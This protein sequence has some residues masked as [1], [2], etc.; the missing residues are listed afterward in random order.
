MSGSFLPKTRG[1]T[2]LA[3]LGVSMAF[4]CP[5]AADPVWG[6]ASTLAAKPAPLPGGLHVS[7]LRYDE[8]REHLGM[9]ISLP[10]LP[11][12]S[13]HRDIFTTKNRH[14][15]WRNGG[16]SDTV[17][18]K[19]PYGMVLSAGRSE[20][21]SGGPMGRHREDEFVGLTFS[22][23]HYRN[24][25]RVAPKDR[26]SVDRGAP[27]PDHLKKRGGMGVFISTYTLALVALLASGGD[28]GGGGGAT[29]TTTTSTTTTTPDDD[30]WTLAWSDEFTGSTLDTS[31]WSSTD[32]YGRDECFG[33][34]NNEQQCYSSSS[35][36]VSI[37]DGKLVL[38]ARPA[39]GLSQ[40]RTYTSG[41][42]QSNGKGD[43]TYGKIEARIKLP[44]GQ[45]SWPAFW[46]LPSDRTYGQWPRSGEIDVVESV[47]LGV[48]NERTVHGTIHY[49]APHAYTGGETEL[50]DINAFHTYAVEWYSDE[51]RWF[52]DGVQY[53]RKTSNQ[54]FSSGA[55]NDA[56][57]PF[58]QDF[59]LILNLAIG[60]QWPGNTDGQNFP[61]QMEIDYVRVYECEGGDPDACK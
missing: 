2:G 7:K 59:H 41:R 35:Q 39:S 20:H 22:S 17:R 11:Q 54:W 43:F 60:G 25:D 28:G 49:G 32:S 56:N 5:A 29:T 40:G 58:D 24:A 12:A 21:Y 27:M 23:A 48:N 6:D 46:M 47:N 31:K 18:V 9:A 13:Y 36:N 42:V 1:L 52:V 33:G 8:E 19:L 34:G 30:G 15:N 61:R 4:A 51:M 44:S 45:G 57:A 38:T 53:S 26:R 37:A 50:S 16:V 14:H 3:V 55:S 10:F